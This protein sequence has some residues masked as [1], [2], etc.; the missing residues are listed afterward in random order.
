VRLINYVYN[1][2]S[3]SECAIVPVPKMARLE[4]GK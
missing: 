2:I 3:L 4:G 1:L